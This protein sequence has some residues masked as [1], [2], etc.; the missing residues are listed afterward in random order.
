MTGQ[1]PSIKKITAYLNGELSDKEADEVINWYNQSDESK[2]EL[3]RLEIIWNLAGRLDLMEK[4]DKQKAKSIISSRIEPLQSRWKL[5][6]KHFQK[7][8]AILIFPVML[9]S[10]WLL[11]FHSEKEFSTKQEFVAAYGIRSTLIL[12]DGSK[13]WLNSGSKLNYGE[14]FN[15]DHRTVYLTGEAFFNVTSNKAKPFDVVTEHFTVRAVGTEFNVFA[16]G[17][18]EFETS[19]EKGSVQLFK[20]RQTGKEPLLEMKPGQRALF[21]QGQMT[22]LE[23]DVTRFSAWREGKLIFKNTSMQEAIPKLERWFN[24]DIKLKDSELMK[25]QF[26]AIFK[27][28]T[29]QQALEMLSFSSP[30]QYKIISG[31]KQQDDIYAKSKIEISMQNK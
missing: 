20:S 1:Y 7:V 5:Y 27:N 24:V 21:E 25:Y 14:D 6:L 23:G 18:S 8:A 30:I 29:I 10:V 3:D 31:E 12:P 26:T 4:I 19:L 13:V 2:K 16:Y 28:E 11:F 9:L 22:I 17:G 15:Q